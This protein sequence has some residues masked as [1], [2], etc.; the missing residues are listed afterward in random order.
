MQVAH[1][2]SVMAEADGHSLFCGRLCQSLQ[3]REV[4]C[5]IFTGTAPGARRLDAG[6]ARVVAWP[7][8]PGGSTPRLS[9]GLM[10]AADAFLATTQPDLVHIHGLWHPVVHAG[11]RAAVRRRLPVVMSLHGMLTGWAWRYHALR[12][13]L[14]WLAYQRRD[15]RAA[16]LVHATSALEVREA[17]ECGLRAPAVIVPLGV[18]PPAEAP[19]PRDSS[20]GRTVLFLSRIHPKKGLPALIRA[21]SAARRPGW[22]L[23]IAGPDEGGHQAAVRALAAS[24]GVLDD[25]TFAGPLYGSDREQAFRDADLFVLPSH[26]ENFGA[27]VAEALVRGVPVITTRATPWSALA[28]ASCGWWVDDS[29]EALARALNEALALRPEERAAMGARGRN[30]VDKP[31]RWS[32][33]AESMHAAYGWIL[34]GGPPPIEISMVA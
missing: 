24:C 20:S 26:S 18:D 21:W 22:R 13:R 23:V 8:A 17:R 30:L 27:V 10:T 25:L 34:T 16:A 28:E 3:K 11:V 12:K 1:F 33:V 31:F 2:I 32:T 15:L 29:V 9:A 4:G 6:G 5:A 19:R 14:A 7:P